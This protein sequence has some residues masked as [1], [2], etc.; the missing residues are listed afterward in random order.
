MPLKKATF[1]KKCWKISKWDNKIEN[2][3][4]GNICY[5]PENVN[6]V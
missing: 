5:V 3:K 4:T 2:K 1:C 6:Y